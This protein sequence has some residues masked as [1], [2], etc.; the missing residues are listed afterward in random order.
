[1]VIDQ[2]LD[3]LEEDTR[4]RVLTLFE[5]TLTDTAVVDIGRRKERG[6]FFTRIVHLIKDPRTRFRPL[7][8]VPTDRLAAR[9]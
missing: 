3:G 2:A 4:E 8:S 5:K 1:V 7:R 9:A 6:R